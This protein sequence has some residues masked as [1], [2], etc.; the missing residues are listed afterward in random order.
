MFLPS[1]KC[2]VVTVIV[3]VVATVVATVALPFQ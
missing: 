1:T 2:M 3:T